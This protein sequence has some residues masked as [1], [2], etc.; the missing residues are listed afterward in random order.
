MLL[1]ED[2]QMLAEILSDTLSERGFDIRIAHDGEQAL[3]LTRLEEW[4][5][6]VSDVMKD[7]RNWLCQCHR[8]GLYEM[9]D[10]AI[11]GKNVTITKREAYEIKKD[12]EYQIAE[13][14]RIM[15]V[16]GEQE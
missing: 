4:D 8:C 13:I 12:I 14:E 3:K 15:N 1:A 7:K 10:G 11:S 6:I 5:V 16:R 9:H 2:E